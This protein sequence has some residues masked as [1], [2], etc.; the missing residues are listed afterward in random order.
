MILESLGAAETLMHTIANR[1]E[2]VTIVNADGVIQAITAK[3]AALSGYHSKD[4][5]GTPVSDLFETENGLWDLVTQSTEERTISAKLLTKSGDKLDVQLKAK[6]V[7]MG[8]GPGIFVL[9]L[10]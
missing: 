8:A 4:I 7:R 2:G 3:L 5:C 10:L 1:D 9:T 6:H